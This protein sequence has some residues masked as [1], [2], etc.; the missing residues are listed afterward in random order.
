MGFP[1]LELREPLM[2]I[3]F[4]LMDDLYRMG[5]VMVKCRE[6]EFHQ[7][8]TKRASNKRWSLTQGQHPAKKQQKSETSVKY[9]FMKHLF[10]LQV[11]Y[12]RVNNKD[13]A[14]ES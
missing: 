1:Y 7:I 13:V 2:V 4:E 14:E 11:Q 8:I 6:R 9:G 3:T 5:E 12:L 10:L